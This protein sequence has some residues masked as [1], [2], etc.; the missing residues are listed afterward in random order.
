MGASYQ[1]SFYEDAKKACNHDSTTNA[2]N[3]QKKTS[4]AKADYNPTQFHYFCMYSGIVLNFNFEYKATLLKRSDVSCSIPI[5]RNEIDHAS[6]EQNCGFCL[7]NSSLRLRTVTWSQPSPL[8][9]LPRCPAPTSQ[10]HLLP[11]AGSPSPPS[12]QQSPLTQ[13]LDD[14]S[15]PPV[16]EPR[17]P[18]PPLLKEPPPPVLAAGRRRW[19]ASP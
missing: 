14:L 17:K 7:H 19:S 6:V 18:S 11:D 4:I 5:S 16:S 13:R 15:R 1:Q 12:L 8:G 3:W 10:S 9:P 2:T